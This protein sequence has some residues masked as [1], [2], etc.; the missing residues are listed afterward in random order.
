MSGAVA[1]RR[2]VLRTLP[3][4]GL[5]AM[6][7]SRDTCGG[8]AHC[9]VNVAVL[10]PLWLPAVQWTVAAAV[11]GVCVEG[12]HVQETCPLLSAVSVVPKLLLLEWL[13]DA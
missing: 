8:I 2:R 4:A 7:R 11:P 1:H 13:P 3:V 12:F 9:T 5:V 10:V 6:V